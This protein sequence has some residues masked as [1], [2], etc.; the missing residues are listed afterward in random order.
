MYDFPTGADGKG[1]CIAL[2]ELGGGFRK[3]DL[4]AY[5]SDLGISAPK[6]TAISV[7]RARNHPGV[8]D[9]DEVML[10]IEVAGAVAQGA[11]IAV[12]F[13][14]NTDRGFLDAI[15][16]AIHDSRRKPSVI[17]ISWGAPETGP[18]DSSWTPQAMRAFDQAFQDAA[19][20]GV[21]VFCASGDKGSSD[22]VADGLAHCDFPASSPFVAA[23]GGTRLVGSNGKIGQEA[24]WNDSQ[25]ATGGG[26]SEIFDLPSYQ[27]NANVPKSTNPGGVKGRGVPDVAGNASPATGYQV[28]VDG[29]DSVMGGTSAVAPLWAGLIA[30]INQKL[31]NRVG[32]I[33]PL[34]YGLPGKAFRDITHGDNGA[35]GARHG[36]DPCTG[37]GSPIGSKL[38]REL[39]AQAR[40]GRRRRAR[41]RVTAPHAGAEV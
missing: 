13:A 18:G 41:P 31:G 19:A 40:T 15:T 30:R 35:Y 26:I 22:G 38:L 27:A 8:Q 33:N 24:V 9:D 32:F 10:D 25:G 29:A 1:Q 4:K 37:L 6:V 11:K 17:S 5:F 12:Y 28:R 21:T 7:D 20:V 34:L 36:W 2:I 16:K 3:S 14:P 23:C 39:S